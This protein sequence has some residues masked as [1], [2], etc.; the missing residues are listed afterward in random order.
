MFRPRI[1]IVQAVGGKPSVAYLGGD[2]AEAETAYR[3]A[4]SDAGN[5]LVQLFIAPQ[6]TRVSRP[7]QDAEVLKAHR[8]ENEIALERQAK[9]AS[10]AAAKAEAHAKELA[11]KAKEAVRKAQSVISAG[12]DGPTEPETK[13]SV[14]SKVK[15][16]KS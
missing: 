6:P 4:Y 9:N 13:P 8:R 7:A 16:S 5:E 2:T 12:P 3:K 11:A 10:E 1:V 14:E 15:K